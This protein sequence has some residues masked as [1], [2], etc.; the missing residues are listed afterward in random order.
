[1]NQPLKP[2]LELIRSRP[3]LYLGK[4]SLTALFHLIG[5]W[6]LALSTYELSDTIH[7]NIPDNFSDW[8]AYRLHFEETSSGWLKMILERS[9][10]ES[11]A[12]ET[13]FELLDEYRI[14]KPRLVAKLIGYRK[15][16]TLTESPQGKTTTC[17]YPDSISLITYTNDPGFFAHS[18]DNQ[19][20]PHQGFQPSIEWF[21]SFTGAKRNQL[22]IIDEDWNFGIPPK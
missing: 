3:P 16:F 18:D 15:A 22:T 6:K 14:R 2:Y 10:S 7:F 11:S 5:G 13:F 4:P 12:F 1:M 8:V 21:E 19:E 9:D 20:F 17:H